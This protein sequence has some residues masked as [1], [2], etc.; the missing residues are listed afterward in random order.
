MVDE[1]IYRKQLFLGKE[2]K[3]H[4]L[5]K[6]IN[7][8]YGIHMIYRKIVKRILDIIFSLIFIVILSPVFLI[9][10]ICIKVCDRGPVFY[11]QTRCTKNG[12]HFQIYKFRSMIKN[13]EEESKPQLT[14]ENDER[15]TKVGKIIRRLKID[16][17]PQLINILKGDMSFVG[18]RPE[19]PELIRDILK[20]LPEFSERTRVRAGLTGYAQI[21]GNYYSTPAEKLKWDMEYI[22]KYSFIFDLKIILLTLPSILK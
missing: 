9:V 12:K 4:Y 17:L 2:N 18:P 15:I 14:K 13:A 11:S 22:E 5:K 1:F 8:L 16:E 7:E 21:K 6:V 10:S 20:E 3:I 19:R